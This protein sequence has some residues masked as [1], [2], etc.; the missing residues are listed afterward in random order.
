MV[1]GG[2][3][4]CVRR[5]SAAYTFQYEAN[6]TENPAMPLSRPAFLLTIFTFLALT[7]SWLNDLAAAEADLVTVKSLQS[8]DLAPAQGQTVTYSIDVSNNGPANATAVSVRDKLPKALAATAQNGSASKGYYEYGTWDIGDLAVGESASLLLEG[9]VNGCDIGDTITNT[10][11]PAVSDLPDLTSDGDELTVAVAVGAPSAVPL[12]A[13]SEGTGGVSASGAII[14][15]SGAPSGWSRN[16]INSAPLSEL[17]ILTTYYLGWKV[18]GDPDQTTWIIGLGETESDSTW[19]DVDHGLRSSAGQLAVYQNGSWR[20]NGPQ[21]TPGDEIGIAVSPGSIDFLLN[22]QILYSGSY[23]GSPEF[24]VDS[25]F[26]SG[27]ISL[28]ASFVNGDKDLVDGGSGSDGS[29]NTVPLSSWNEGT[30]GVRASDAIMDYIGTPTGWQKNTINSVPLSQVGAT[31]GYTVH[32]ELVGDPN[33]TMWVVGLGETESGSSWRDIDY[34]L[35]SSLGQLSVYENGSWK[36]SGP[37]LSSGDVLSIAVSPGAIDYLLNDEILYRTSYAGAPD[38]YVDSSFKEGAI[39]FAVSVTGAGSGS[40]GSGGDDAVSINGW[41]NAAGGATSVG[42]SI[43]YSGTPTGWSNTINSLAFA[44]LGASSDYRVAWTLGSDPANSTWIVGL[45]VTETGANWRDVEF[46]LRSSGGVLKVYENGISVAAGGRV[47]EDDVLSIRVRGDTI[48]YELNGDVIH[49]TTTVLPADYYLDSSF[50]DGAISLIDFVWFDLSGEH[51]PPAPGEECLPPDNNHPPTADAGANVDA[52]VGTTVVLVGSGLDTDGDDLTFQWSLVSRPDGSSLGIEDPESQSISLVPDVAGDYLLTLAVDDGFAASAAN[53]IVVTAYSEVPRGDALETMHVPLDEASGS[54]ISDI[55]Q[56]IDNALPQEPQWVAGKVGDAAVRISGS[57]AAIALD[58]PFQYPLERFSVALWVKPLGFDPDDD[59][60]FDSILANSGSPADAGIRLQMDNRSANALLF[61]IDLGGVEYSLR[62][63]TIPVP[64]AWYHVAASY[65]GSTIRLFINGQEEASAAAN[66]AIDGNTDVLV[67]GGGEAGFAI[68][69]EIDDLRVYADGLT[70]PEIWDLVALGDRLA[71]AAPGYAGALESCSMIDVGAPVFQTGQ[72]GFTDA[73]RLMMNPVMEPIGDGISLFVP[74]A[75]FPAQTL[76]P[77]GMLDVTMPPFNADATGRQD[78]TASIQ[79]AIDAAV[80]FTLAVFFPPGEYLVSDTIE[81]LQPAYR[82]SNGYEINDRGPTCALM[83]STAGSERPR[84]RLEDGADGF[85]DPGAPKPVVRILA[86]NV[87][88]SSLPDYNSNFD[89]SFV[90]IDI[91]VG[92]LNYGAAGL[93]FRGAQGSHVED[94]TV[95][96]GAG[97]AGL[98]GANGSGGLTANVAVVGGQVGI[99]AFD[100]GTQPMATLVGLN[101]IH[102]SGPAITYAGPNEGMTL[103]GARIVAPP[104]VGGPMVFARGATATE[105]QIVI[106]DSTFEFEDPGQNTTLIDTNRG[107]VLHNSYA[108]NV[109]VAVKFNGSDVLQGNPNDWRHF[110]EFAYGVPGEIARSFVVSAPNYLDNV[111]Q[112][113]LQFTVLGDD[114]APP[115]T[116]A[117]RH[118]WRE[119]D[120]P[121]PETP[122]AVNVRDSPYFATGDGTTDDYAAIQAAVDENEIVFFPKGY[123]RISRTLQ[124]RED[125]KLLSV[126]G[127]LAFLIPHNDPAGD[128]Y[129]D[130]DAAQEEYDNGIEPVE[131]SPKPLVVTADSATAETV[132]SR[133]GLFT[134]KNTF[135]SFPMLWRSGGKSIIR[136]LVSRH[137]GQLPFLARALSVTVNHP[138]FLLT[139]NAGGRIYGMGSTAPTGSEK[140]P[141]FR[142]VR[143][144]GTTAPLFFYMLNPEHNISEASIEIRNSENVFVYGTKFEGAYPLYWLADSRN[145]NIF[146]TGGN[147]GSKSSSSSYPVTWEQ[148]TPSLIRIERSTDVRITTQ[149]DRLM[150]GTFLGVTSDPPDTWHAII[151]LDV[152]GTEHRT[153]ILDRPTLLI[154]GAPT[155]SY[156]Q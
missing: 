47:A 82:R 36:T 137:R 17:T 112:N 42:N 53:G 8:S 81:C 144:E 5:Q 11:E 76:L 116:L 15:Y 14:S 98:L 78:A 155:D 111:R 127:A 120:F 145:V 133:L 3:G 103:V 102:Q 50:K 19:R 52:A 62:S 9:I 41:T 151:N 63:R 16:T 77:C 125:S 64:N 109:D 148:Y 86:L 135:S 61:N 152:S 126:S 60:G 124:L 10:A 143:V 156:L 27:A 28:E 83:G 128:F 105:G 59:R 88:D 93:A 104:G 4:K 57:G 34:G 68:D 107:V 25:S 131:S 56:N 99:E 7:S 75:Y 122:G 44:S 136:H 13:W 38:F 123:Y 91:D 46:G 31:T 108:R 141:L 100:F 117:T 79:A 87:A 97:Y 139:G 33:A 29:G 85:A 150:S 115:A 21:L 90:G 132:M 32:W 70:A 106:A 37:Q 45:G 80:E 69:A 43:S 118:I 96:A 74:S 154:L 54:S 138:L 84:L 6:A 146:G 110:R 58:S 153:D 149:M 18:I 51:S 20:A 92:R 65:D 55:V 26:K 30:G 23:T 101:L 142:Q 119:V 49:T 67:I 35:R 24:Y 71:A 134:D 89:N 130:I 140:N 39:S 94:V 73:S 1:R 121:T 72:Q 48:D 147:G 22:G 95:W 40:S 66:G 113:E 114:S 129:R 12:T 2:V